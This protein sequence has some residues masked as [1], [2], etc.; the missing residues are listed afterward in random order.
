MLKLSRHQLRMI[1]AFL[2][3]HDPLK[4]HLNTMSLFHGNPDCRFCK[5]ETE[6]MYHIICCCEVLACQH[7]NFFGKFFVEPK[8]I[9][10][11]S[12][13]DLCLFVRDIGLMILC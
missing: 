13:K 10:M 6:I 8:D 11:S 4:K 1:V 7:Y 5:M 12:L 9:S 2:T 3:G